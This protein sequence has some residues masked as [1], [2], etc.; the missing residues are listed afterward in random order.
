MNVHGTQES[1]KV[2]PLLLDFYCDIVVGWFA[3]KLWKGRQWLEIF[4][5]EFQPWNRGILYCTTP[6]FLQAVAGVSLT[7]SILLLPD[8]EN[9]DPRKHLHTSV[10]ILP[11][12]H[13]PGEN[14]YEAIVKLAVHARVTSLYFTTP[15]L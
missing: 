14:G 10:P 4:G 15:C 3:T 5:A 13:P 6:W 1:P 11:Q 7:V 8:R 12:S 9:P 2:I